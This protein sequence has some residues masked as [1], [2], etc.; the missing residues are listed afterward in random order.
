MNHQ[1]YYEDNSCRILEYEIK[2]LFNQNI[3]SISLKHILMIYM[4]HITIIPICDTLHIR[5]FVSQ[6]PHLGT[7]CPV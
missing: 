5:C 2:L 7:R 4:S 1:P 3:L 6:L